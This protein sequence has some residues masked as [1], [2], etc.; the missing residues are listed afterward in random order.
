MIAARKELHHRRCRRPQRMAR[1]HPC[2]SQ[3]ASARRQRRKSQRARH[4]CWII[5]AA[6]FAL[7]RRLPPSSRRRAT[8]KLDQLKLA[9]P[10]CLIPTISG[11][12]LAKR[13]FGFSIVLAGFDR[14]DA[15]GESLTPSSLSPPSVRATQLKLPVPFMDSAETCGRLVFGCT[16]AGSSSL[17]EQPQMLHT[18]LLA[19]VDATFEL[20]VLAHIWPPL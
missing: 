4:H 5:R 17:A 3:V 8:D 19:L 11:T 1:H 16:E 13:S 7:G 18:S 12:E 2:I 14:R 6:F 9:T 15:H 10:T 20:P